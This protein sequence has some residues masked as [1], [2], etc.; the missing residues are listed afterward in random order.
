MHRLHTLIYILFGEF[1]CLLIW[2][3]LHEF[4]VEYKI[5]LSALVTLFIISSIENIIIS[6]FQVIKSNCYTWLELIGS[7]DIYYLQWGIFSKFFVMFTFL[8]TSVTNNQL[9]LRIFLILLSKLL[10]LFIIYVT[11]IFLWQNESFAFIFQRM[12]NISFFFLFI[13]FHFI[14]YFVNSLF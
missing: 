1:C 12:V 9:K 6:F 11:F 7:I 8:D 5:K 3:F 10:F 14:H 4:T 2:Q 13:L